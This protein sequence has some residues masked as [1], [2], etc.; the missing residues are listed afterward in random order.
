M[1]ST[2]PA[3]TNSSTFVI[4]V[5]P[6]TQ[7]TPVTMV[8]HA[9]VPLWG[10]QE[11]LKGQPKAL[12]TVQIMIGLL[13]LLFGIVST[14]NGF[15]AFVISGVPYWGS[16]MYITSGALCIAAENQINSPSSLCLVNASLG[17]NIFSTI[18]AGISIIFISLDLVMRPYPYCTTY[19]YVFGMYQ[20]LFIGIRVVLLL[21]AVLEFII[22]ICLSAF[23][24]KTC[25]CS[26]QDQ[27]R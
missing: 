6:A 21:F 9:P 3:N 24:C 18:T 15:S 4:Q 11:F 27:G 12:G 8:T 14:F 23:A 5:Q 19:C 13:T 1:S 17:M 22:S 20:T 10:I 7:A 25:C 26:S 2:G 16:I